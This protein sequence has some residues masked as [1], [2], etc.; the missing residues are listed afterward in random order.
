MYDL[1]SQKS[2]WGLLTPHDNPYDGKSATIKGA[3]PDQWGYPTGGERADY[4]DFI[5]AVMKA[6]H[7]VE[8]QLTGKSNGGVNNTGAAHP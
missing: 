5:S 1:D 7:L 4:G 6:N 3:G 2:N 8:P